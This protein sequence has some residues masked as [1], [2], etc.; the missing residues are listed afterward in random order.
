[1]RAKSR[2]P[3]LLRSAKSPAAVA[4]RAQFSVSHFA[5]KPIA[6]GAQQQKCDPSPASGGGLRRR[7]CSE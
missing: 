3:A 1:V 7:E 6:E 5:I 2:H 4:G